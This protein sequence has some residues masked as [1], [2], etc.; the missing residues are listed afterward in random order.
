MITIAFLFFLS[1]FAALSY[2]VLWQRDLGLIFGNT[3]HAAA[4]VTAIF[5]GGI[6][7]GAYAAGKWA[8]RLKRPIRAFA[9]LEV[10]IG[11]YALMV[12]L[13]FS[14]LRILYRFSYQNVS[15]ALPFLTLVRFVS[16]VMVLLV[17][18]A[19]MGA[20]LP[21]LCKGLASQQ[22]RFGARIGVLYGMNTLGAVSG[23]VMC[24]FVM[25][26]SLGMTNSRYVAVAVSLLVG[27]LAFVAARYLGDSAPTEAIAA[28]PEEK[29]DLHRHSATPL[30]W[31]MGASGF[32]GLAFEVTWFRTLILVFGSTTYSFSTML[33]VFLAGI[34]LGALLLGWISDRTKSPGSLFGLSAIGI[35][36]YSISSLYWFDSMPELLLKQLAA[37]G[38]TWHNMVSA[39]VLI[40]LIFLFVPALLF[41]MSF[42]AASR[43]IRLRVASSS[44]TVG[45][46]TAFNTVGAA[47]GAIITG[48]WVLPALGM[49]RT[50]LVLSVLA[51]VLGTSLTIGFASKRITKTAV[52]CVAIAVAAFAIVAPPRWDKQVLSAGPYFTPW[53]YVQGGKLR[54][55]QR[56][57]SER[58]L[59]FEEG[60]TSTIS[61]VHD[62]D[63]DFFFS[64]NGKVEADTGPRSMILQRV[65]GHL[66]MLFH[67]A[68]RTVMNIGLGAGVT[69]GALGCYPVDHLEVVEIEPAVMNV[70]RVWGDRNHR[71]VERDDA[72]ITINDGRNHLF[73]TARKYDVITSDP[74]EP[75]M[76]GAA[77][78]YSVE[79]FE[80][81]R[82]C[83]A[84]GGIMAQFLPLYE[85]SKENYLTIARSFVHV[86][87]RTVLF[88]TGYDSVLVGFTEDAPID[89]TVARKNY[90]IPAV[91][92]SLSE[93]G[94][95]AP[96]MVLGMVVADLSGKPELLGEGPLNTDGFPV[97]EFSAPRSTLHYTPD[98]NFQALLD[99]FAPLSE[100][101]TAGLQPEEVK[102]V[103]AEHMAL[104]KTLEAGIARAAKDGEAVV[105]H[106]NAALTL[107]PNN[108]V[109][110]NEMVISLA[111][112]ADNLRMS[113]DPRTAFMQ[114]QIALQ[115][116]PDAFWPLYHLVGLAMGNRNQKAANKFLDKGLAAYPESPLFIALRGRMK[117]TNGDMQGACEDLEKAIDQLPNRKDFWED[118]AFF[119]AAKGDK[120]AAE[121]AASRAKE[122]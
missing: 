115:Y 65:M 31:A 4:T 1:G 63:E 54:L 13:L 55:Q 14:G 22:E 10:A 33:G 57:Q 48:F 77:N 91:A 108:P 83:L 86:F 101:L 21:V 40:A 111:S 24:G 17:P 62:A 38:F 116:T 73:A 80:Q 117:G 79:H 45:R 74:F 2:E 12:P 16:G 112:S 100:G 3:V 32:L 98:H 51:F 49:E 119:L 81:A 39:K 25:I 103:T 11:L 29:P 120:S 6:A 66:P 26:P 20:T 53:Q 34:S 68:P 122:L 107:A 46:A 97:I 94:F 85:L 110:R 58:L 99:C 61:T 109:I 28:S 23:V 19:L 7:L 84:K 52:V 43:A 41:G 42:T 82:Q 9:G 44:Q 59:F 102:R 105:T 35:G 47:L 89:L 72:I 121:E 88:F 114:Y 5:M 18:T 50:L 90:Q 30:L 113:G 36:V 27:I 60:K 76:A 67:P 56:L 118:Y 69:F 78:L 106:L 95:T 64:S 96:E 87:P 71:I 75:V 92:S 93:V 15:D 8:E 37:F 70:A 104:A